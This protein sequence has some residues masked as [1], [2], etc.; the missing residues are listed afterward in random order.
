VPIAD[1]TDPICSGPPGVSRGRAYVRKLWPS[2]A[3]CCVL[4]RLERRLNSGAALNL[5]R[6]GSPVRSAPSEER[7][8]AAQ[9]RGGISDGRQPHARALTVELSGRPEPPHER[10]RRTLS[11]RRR[12]RATVGLSR[13]ASTVVRG[14]VK[15]S[16]CAPRAR[17]FAY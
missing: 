11:F 1:R 9:R 8:M 10:R 13:T 6:N 17:G 3:A 15:R 5:I 2:Y 4:V 12:P 14:R 7:W 16:H